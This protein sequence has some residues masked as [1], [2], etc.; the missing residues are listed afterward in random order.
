[1]KRGARQTVLEGFRKRT[2]TEKPVWTALTQ[3]LRFPHSFR[4]SLGHRVGILQWFSA[5][6]FLAFFC[7]RAAGLPHR[8]QKDFGQT[9]FLAGH[10][11]A[12]ARAAPIILAPIQL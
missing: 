12:A 2:T 3:P 9:R 6:D 4:T 5:H 11:E 1:M 7:A 8:L 10:S